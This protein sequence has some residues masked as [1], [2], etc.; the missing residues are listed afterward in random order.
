[1]QLP[2][3]RLATLEDQ[4]LP[5]FAELEAG[6][7]I[8]NADLVHSCSIVQ[9]L[10]RI[11]GTLQISLQELP[12]LFQLESAFRANSCRKATGYD[13]LPS[14]LFHLA[15]GPMA[16]V[17]HDLFLKEFMWQCEPIQAKGGPVATIPKSAQPNLAKQFRGILLLPHDWKASIEH[18]Y[19]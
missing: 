9:A 17:F 14:D 6:R 7:Q 1:M 2:P 8:S 13:P 19:G 11:D 10:R 16:A 5:H 4:W 3:A 18:G 12:S 15:S